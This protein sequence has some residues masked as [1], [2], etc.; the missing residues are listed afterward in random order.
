MSDSLG[1]AQNQRFEMRSH[2]AAECS[3]IV[4]QVV[5]GIVSRR[6]AVS[7]PAGETQLRSGIAWELRG[8]LLFDQLLRVFSS[9]QPDVRCGEVGSGRIGK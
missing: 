6:L 4:E 1:G 5:A 3:P 2:L 7:H 8:L 9:A